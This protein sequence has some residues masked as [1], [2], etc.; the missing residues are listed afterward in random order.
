MPRFL[1]PPSV[2]APASRYS[3]GVLIGP[4]AKRL[5]I[6]G[7]VGIQRDGTL[8]L[9]FKEQLELAF[10]NLLAVVE[11][12]QL[13]LTDIVK[14]VTYVTVPGSIAVYRE[15]R[16]SKLGKHAPAATYIEVAGLAD[17]R[18]LVE[19]EGEAVREIA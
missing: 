6:S 16:E 3:H 12:A 2:R 15:V 4:Q 17:P 19:I 1:N 18:F 14:I 11:N 7:Q 10:D 9:A 8:P 5:L 13:E